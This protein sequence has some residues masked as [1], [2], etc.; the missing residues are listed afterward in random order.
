MGDNNYVLQEKYY[1][2]NTNTSQNT[3]SKI[4]T[5]I[6][7][8]HLTPLNTS[9]FSHSFTNSLILP[10]DLKNS[11][12]PKKNERRGKLIFLSL[13]FFHCCI[14]VSTRKEVLCCFLLLNS[15]KVKWTLSFIVF[16]SFRFFIIFG[17]K[18]VENHIIN[19]FPS[20]NS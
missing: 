9:S 8:L 6:N 20:L 10:L 15:Y 11:R 3:P 17:E 1:K 14:W 16:F 2:Y 18:Y 13:L 19:C 4:R 12:S 7:S 5:L